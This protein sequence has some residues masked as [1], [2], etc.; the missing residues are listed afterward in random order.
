MIDKLID[1]IISIIDLFRFWQVIAA[2]QR[3]IVLR[4]GVFHREL[5]PGLHWIIPFG[6]DHVLDDNVVP[7]TVALG[8]QSLVTND[9]HTV[10]VS[11][12]VT[13]RIRD[14]QKALLEVEGVDHALVDSCSAAVAEHVARSTWDELRA[15][16]S[17][18]TLLKECRQQAFRY[19]IEIIRVQL[20]E[21]TTCRV[22]RLHSA[23]GHSTGT[24]KLL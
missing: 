20:A 7:R 3:G 2:Y 4:L 23:T 5:E 8:A 9:G 1:L 16:A 24:A 6:I 18:K 19:G 17:A 15:E 12:V 11:P 21:I 14:I 22:I 10:A 13:A